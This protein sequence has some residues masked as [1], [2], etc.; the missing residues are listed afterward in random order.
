MA[1]PLCGTKSHRAF[2]GNNLRLG[3]CNNINI[4][5]IYSKVLTNVEQ[6]DFHV[7][8]PIFVI[9]THHLRPCLHTFTMSRF[10]GN[11]QEIPLNFTLGTILVLKPAPGKHSGQALESPFD[12]NLFNETGDMLLC[13]SISTTRIT[14]KDHALRSLGEGRG[15]EQTVDINVDRRVHIWGTQSRFII[16]GLIPNSG[17]IKYC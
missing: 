4:Y 14:F 8:S 10:L 1:S 12:L 11:N 15:K 17:D 7:P 6:R 13:I 3:L 2:P 16:I 5:V 9:G